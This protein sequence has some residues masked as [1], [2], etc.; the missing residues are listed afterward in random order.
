MTKPT[1]EEA[2]ASIHAI[3]QSLDKDDLTLQESLDKFEEG[4]NLSKHCQNLLKNAQKKI[5]TITGDDLIADD[6]S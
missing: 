4:I 6:D 5:D 2:M 3:T 1:F